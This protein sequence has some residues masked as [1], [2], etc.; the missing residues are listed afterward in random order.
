LLE[1]GSKF[2]HEL[3]SQLP[4]TSSN[5]IV[6]FPETAI[7]TI[8]TKRRDFC[9][10]YDIYGRRTGNWHAQRRIF[11]RRVLSNDSFRSQAETAVQDE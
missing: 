4:P 1:S 8:F 7:F 6:R 2:P 5:H 11:T 3:P 9:E 10:I